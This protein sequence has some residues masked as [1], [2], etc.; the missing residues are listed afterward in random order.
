VVPS[1]KTYGP[2]SKL[3]VN[4]QYTDPVTKNTVYGTVLGKGAASTLT[5]QFQPPF[6]S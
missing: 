4:V 1:S 5:I 3:V 2:T 6:T